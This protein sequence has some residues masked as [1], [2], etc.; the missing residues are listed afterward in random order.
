MEGL[1][2]AKAKVQG[3]RGIMESGSEMAVIIA[4]GAGMEEVWLSRAFSS[5]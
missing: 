5:K 1:Q 2:F 3:M 4:D